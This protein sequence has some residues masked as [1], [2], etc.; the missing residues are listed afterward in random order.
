MATEFMM[1]VDAQGRPHGATAAD[2]EVMA[3]LAGGTYRTVCTTPRGRS[4]SA[5]GLWFAM[6]Q[7]IADNHPADLTK[8]N[9]SDTLKIECGHANVWQDCTGLYRRSPKSIAFN[10]MS[11]EDFSKLLDL[12]LVKAGP[13]FGDDLTAA[14]I[15]ELEKMGAPDLREA[16]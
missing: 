7:L 15:A 10:A 5:L 8:E 12:A 14:V 3:G 11:G 1:T 16:A 4:L 9:V 13:L 2:A 6:C